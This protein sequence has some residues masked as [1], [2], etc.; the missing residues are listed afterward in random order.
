M[1]HTSKD[2]IAQ[3]RLYALEKV[4]IQSLTTY[5]HFIQLTKYVWM[6][7]DGNYAEDW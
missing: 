6:T 2:S 3:L 5:L 1:F 4:T 7:D